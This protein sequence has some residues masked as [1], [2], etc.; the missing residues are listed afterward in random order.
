MN[1]EKGKKVKFHYTLSVDD[2][3][4][5]TSENE[6]P[7]SYTHGS[8][9][10]IPGLAAGLEGM[11]EGDEKSINVSAENAYG[12]VNPEAFSEIP[13]SSLPKG[14][15]PQEEMILQANT[16]DGKAIPV[17]ISAVKDES[18]IIDLNHPLAGKNLKFDVKI[19]SVE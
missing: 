9:Q 6:G 8:G 13:K 14:L 1:I 17:R 15:D 10:I 2:K 18:V 12:A 11:N 5:H 3:I 4:V 19:V 16:A 7:L